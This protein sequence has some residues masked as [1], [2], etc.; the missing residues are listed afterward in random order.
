MSSCL[1]LTCVTLSALNVKRWE[2]EKYIRMHKTIK[3][4]V[5]LFIVKEKIGNE[6]IKSVQLKVLL[7]LI[8]LEQI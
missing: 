5:R 6:N 3:C 7:I 4:V 8:L 1:R 2:S